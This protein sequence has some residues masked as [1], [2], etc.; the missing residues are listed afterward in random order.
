MD[1][2]QPSKQEPAGR[3]ESSQKKAVR[4]QDSTTESSVAADA[5][6][7]AASASAPRTELTKPAPSATSSQLV[8]RKPAK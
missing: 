5:D 7:S 6:A 1:Q 2:T 8:K 3:P 4:F